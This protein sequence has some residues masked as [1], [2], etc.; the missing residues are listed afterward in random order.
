MKIKFLHILIVVT[1]CLSM[2]T[3]LD[4]SVHADAKTHLKPRVE[5]VATYNLNK[6]SKKTLKQFYEMKRTDHNTNVYVSHGKVHVSMILPGGSPK[7]P[8]KKMNFADMP[9]NSD[10]PQHKHHAKKY[11]KKIMHNH[12]KK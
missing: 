6:V 2:I 8:L 1:A 10:E 5:L 11:I 7:S 3:M 9:C 12:N 4:S